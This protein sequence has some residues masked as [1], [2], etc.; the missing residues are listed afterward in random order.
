MLNQNTKHSY[1]LLLHSLSSIG[2]TILSVDSFHPFL[3]YTSFLPGVCS[4]MIPV[5]VAYTSK[6][7]WDEGYD[8]N[9]EWQEF[10]Y[11]WWGFDRKMIKWNDHKSK[12]DH[13]MQVYDWEILELFF[14]HTHNL[15]PIF[16]DQPVLEEEEL[17]NEVK[18]T[19][20]HC[21]IY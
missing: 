6:P 16:K 1:D 7:P 10:A 18:N 17:V 11:N 8:P 15:D 12:G 13:S 5:T 21:R 19:F 4:E 14:T 9:W 3:E 20:F 2:I